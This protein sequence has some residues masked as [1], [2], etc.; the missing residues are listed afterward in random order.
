MYLIDPI[1][2]FKR[3]NQGYISGAETQSRRI[4]QTLATNQK[5]LLRWNVNVNENKSV[6]FLRSYQVSL[7][8]DSRSQNF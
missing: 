7:G 1:L 6:R 4:W 3:N 2:T 8:G 5:C